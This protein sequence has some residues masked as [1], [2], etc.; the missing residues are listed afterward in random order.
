MFVHAL[1]ANKTT[2]MAVNVDNNIAS[3]NILWIGSSSSYYIRWTK[4]DRPQPCVTMQGVQNRAPIQFLTLA[5]YKFIYLLTYLTHTSHINVQIK[6]V[7][8][9]VQAQNNNAYKIRY[10]SAFSQWRHT[11]R[12]KGFSRNNVKAAILK[13]WRHIRNS[14]P[15]FDAYTYLKKNP[16]RPKIHPDRIWKDGALCAVAPS[17]R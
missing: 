8:Y 16:A 11:R 12:A 5:L 3:T 15:S 13:V 17:R 10:C 2:Q 1:Y 9:K 7:K 14:T 4:V 6:T